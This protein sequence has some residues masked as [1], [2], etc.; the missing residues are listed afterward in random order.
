M[1]KI[2]IIGLSEGNGHPY[3]WSAIFNGFDEL[4][5]DKCPFPVIPTYL[6]KEK[7]PENFLT[8]LGRVTHIWTQDPVISHKVATAAKI[9][10]IVTKKE[11]MIGQVDAI[12]LARDDAEN[13]FEMALPFIKAGLPIFIDKPFSLKLSE[14]KEMLALQKYESQLFTCSSL[15]FSNDFK[16]TKDEKDTLGEIV[17]VEGTIIK[18]WETYGV[19]ILEPLI[20][21]LPNRGKLIK[22]DSNKNGPF[23]I[24]N[25]KWENCLAT[26]KLTGDVPSNLSI[27]FSGNNDTIIK[28][29]TD[30]FSSFKQ[31][32]KTFVEMVQ[33][34]K[35]Q[36]PRNETL[37]IVEILENGNHA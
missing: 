22:V 5:M 11:D 23:Q 16:L 29:Y 1:L 15:R 8:E 12:L 17:Y 36:I 18:K 19:H 25:I 24:V 3:S 13:H 27:S 7:F 6:K 30:T 35:I 26:L 31:A 4:E 34:K 20:A 32:L 14:A 9:E 2:G 33:D 21:Q 10:N 28:L 37:E